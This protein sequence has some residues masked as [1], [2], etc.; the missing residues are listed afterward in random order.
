MPV[1]VSPCIPMPLICVNLN[2]FGGVNVNKCDV[3]QPESDMYNCGR[4]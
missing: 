1:K 2:P 4:R 3:E